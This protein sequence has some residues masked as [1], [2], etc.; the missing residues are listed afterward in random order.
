MAR[1]SIPVEHFFLSSFSHNIFHQPSYS[2]HVLALHLNLNL[3]LNLTMQATQAPCKPRKKAN[4]APAYVQ[5]STDLDHAR[6]GLAMTSLYVF[7]SSQMM[8]SF[9]GMRLRLG[10]LCFLV[11]F[12]I[13]AISFE[14]WW[15]GMSRFLAGLII[16]TI[17]SFEDS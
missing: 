17:S 13:H 11:E 7:S 2:P 16:H 9:T 4:I 15:L 12:I 10:M 6:Q 8:T 14:D 3:N 5:A 1:L